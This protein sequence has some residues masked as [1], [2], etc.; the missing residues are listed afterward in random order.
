[1]SAEL[2]PSVSLPLFAADDSAR[3]AA[4]LGVLYLRRGQL[5]SKIC[6]EPEKWR[7]RLRALLAVYAEIEH[8]RV[9]H[10]LAPY[11]HSAPAGEQ[12]SS[13]AA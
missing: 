2:L 13:A 8:H 12:A 4:R 10:A 3:I 11:R 1:V 6:T 7:L 9:A 5:E